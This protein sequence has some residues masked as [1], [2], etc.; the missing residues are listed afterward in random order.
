MYF[1]LPPAK[2]SHIQNINPIMKKYENVKQLDQKQHSVNQPDARK[3]IV[4]LK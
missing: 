3:E 1:S 2:K 4:D